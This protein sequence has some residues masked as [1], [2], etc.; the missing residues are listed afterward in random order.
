MV[1]QFFLGSSQGKLRNKNPV[2]T[3]RIM[4]TMKTVTV[5]PGQAYTPKILLMNLLFES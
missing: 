2:L 4:G 1:I 5:E 3:E